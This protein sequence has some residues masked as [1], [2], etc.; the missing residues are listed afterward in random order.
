[1]RPAMSTIPGAL[2]LGL[3]SPNKHSGPLYDAYRRHYGQNSP[4]LVIQADTRT[5][6]ASVPLSVIDRAMELDP[7]AVGAEYLAQFR[8]DVGTFLVPSL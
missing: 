2:L 4:V 7:G 8:S 1:M 3:S 5:M 6:N